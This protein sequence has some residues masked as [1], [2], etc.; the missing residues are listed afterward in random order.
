[1]ALN[2]DSF[3][4]AQ[5]R[6]DDGVIGTSGADTV[7]WAITVQGGSAVTIADL[8]EG[9]DGSGTARALATAP[10]NDSVTVDCGPNG[11]YFAGGVHLDIT[12][13]GGSVTVVYNQ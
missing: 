1:M 12:T 8:T 9:T 13:T 5:V 3:H 11:I 10:I 2:R 4:T 6:T 7:V